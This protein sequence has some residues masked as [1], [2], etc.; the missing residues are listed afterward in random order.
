MNIFIL[1]FDLLLTLPLS[2]IIIYSSQKGKKNLYNLLLPT[3]YMIIISAIWSQLKTNI[4][5]IPIF[6]LFIR[7]FYITNIKDEYN[8][9]KK[10][11]FYSILSI[12]I[13]TLTYNMF[14]SKVDNVLSQPEEFKSLLWF[15]IIIF[16]YLYFADTQTNTTAHLKSL[17]NKKE[18]VVMQYAKFKTKY[19]TIVNSKNEKINLLTY[20]IMIHENY[21]HP[22]FY[23]SVSSYLN[24]LLNKKN[25]YGIMQ[26]SSPIPLSDEESIKIVLDELE[27]NLKKEDLTKKNI[28][29][30]LK[31]ENELK[32]DEIILIYEYLQDFIKE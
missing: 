1:F 6:E 15:L 23:R 18:Y 21:Q 7:N 20:A 30:Y 5:L 17:A 24:H 8:D 12:I 10:D 32:K 26:V 29:Q 25:Y 14:I 13:S 2:F 27:K 19:G 31:K 16:I 9:N 4:F 3:I 22:V 28:E 11:F